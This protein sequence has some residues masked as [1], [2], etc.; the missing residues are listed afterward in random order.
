MCCIFRWDAKMYRKMKKTAAGIGFLFMSFL[1]TA[2]MLKNAYAEPIAENN[3]TLVQDGQMM[4]YVDTKEGKVLGTRGKEEAGFAF[5]FADYL[6]WFNEESTKGHLDEATNGM[7][8][9]T[10]SVKPLYALAFNE[11]KKDIYLLSGEFYLDKDRES[12]NGS[13]GMKKGWHKGYILLSNGSA[14]ASFYFVDGQKGSLEALD[15]EKH[16]TKGKKAAIKVKMNEKGKI[17]YYFWGVDLTPL[18]EEK[19]PL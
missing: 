4:I 18:S 15:M 2:V 12:K 10:E 3:V 16:F 11:E 14:E 9:K 5:T 19:V 13:G 6:N 17:T 1:F 7:K 8:I